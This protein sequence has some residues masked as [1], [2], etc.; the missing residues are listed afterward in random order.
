VDEF[1][2]SILFYADA[3]ARARVRGAAGSST[4]SL[5]SDAG[6]SS[7]SS[8]TAASSCV[9]SLVQSAARCHLW[10]T[11]GVRRRARDCSER[12]GG[13]GAP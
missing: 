6:S 2:R 5:L 12:G 1:E 13:E 9:S 7:G 8:S 3:H 10:A 4:P 11:C